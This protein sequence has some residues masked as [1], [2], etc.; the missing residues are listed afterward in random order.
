M[1]TLGVILAGGLSRRMG[2]PDKGLIDLAGRPLLA[3]VS[4]R[5]RP[6][7]DTLLLNA[8]G[9]LS[10]FAALGLP[11]I[12]DQSEA[13]EG[14][15]AGICAGMRAARGF[16]YLATFSSDSPLFPTDL[17]ARLHDAV[18]R[19]AD[20]AIAASHGREHPVFGLWP[21]ARAT[22]FAAL[23]ASGVRALRD[24]DRVMTK[25][26]VTFPADNGD[27]FVNANTPADLADLEA[28]LAK[29]SGDQPLSSDNSSR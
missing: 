15:L 21:V 19:G 8:N 11:M 25:A 12:S 22:D 26:V 7:V 27:P 17:V 9:D 28:R 1:R 14:P 18:A 13:G 23:F 10:R 5:A 3:W 24:I 4:E 2:R 6:Q 29:R 16:A 20:Y